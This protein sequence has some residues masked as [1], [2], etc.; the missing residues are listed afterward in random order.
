MRSPLATLA[1]CATTVVRNDGK[2]TDG[3]YKKKLAAR[4]FATRRR[5][6]AARRRRRRRSRDTFAE[7]RFELRFPETR[8]AQWVAREDDRDGARINS[9]ATPTA[10]TKLRKVAQLDKP[11]T[12]GAR[13]AQAWAQAWARADVRRPPAAA[14]LICSSSSAS[15]RRRTA[16]TRHE[17]EYEHDYTCDYYAGKLQRAEDERRAK[18]GWIRGCGAALAR[19]GRVCRSQ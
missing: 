18:T 19:A 2:A 10:R 6:R 15:R 1:P 7:R 4:N 16:T 13:S 5:C 17:Y 8:A 3:A 12:P 9:L 14:R 11:T